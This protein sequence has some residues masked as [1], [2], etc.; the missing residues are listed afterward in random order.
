MAA[1]LRLAIRF[2]TAWVLMGAGPAAALSPSLPLRYHS[3]ADGLANLAV[4]ALA[5]DTAGQLWI[6]TENGLFVHGGARVRA[7]P[8]EPRLAVGRMVSA[9]AAGPAGEV[10]I[11]TRRGLLRWQA[12]AVTPFTRGGKL[13][14]VADGLGLAF[15]PEGRLLVVADRELLQLSLTS[16]GELEPALP[17]ALVESEGRLKEI[18]AVWVGRDGAWWLACG[19][20]LCRWH[21]GTLSVWDARQGLAEARWAGLL[22]ARDGSLWARSAQHVARL[23]PGAAAFE[24]LTTPGLGQGTVHQQQPLL[25]DRSGRILIH[26]D[27]GIARWDAGTWTLFDAGQGLD[28][29]GGVHALLFDRQGDLWLGTA[30]RGLAQWR[31]YGRWSNWSAAP[32]QAAEEVWSFLDGNDG[33]GLW[34]GTGRGTVR[35]DRR[36]AQVTE[37]AA[38]GQ[39]Q[40]QV[41][42]LARDSSRRL[43]LATFSGEL[44]RL[45][46]PRWTRIASGLPLVF[47]ILPRD[48]GLWLGTDQGLY[49]VADPQSPHPAVT[50]LGLGAAVPDD[51]I[52]VFTMCR[53]PAGDVWLAT[54]A[55]LL[56]QRPGEGIAAARPEGLPEGRV[57]NLACGR[58]GALWVHGSDGGLWQVA[59]AGGRW[60]AHRQQA[61]VLA[62]RLIM[63]LLED[64]RGWLWV[65]TDAGLVLRTPAPRW[66]R[67]DDSNGLVWSDCNQYAL[68]EDR[69]GAIWVGTSRGVSR[70]ESPEQ[71]DP[72]HAIGLRLTAARRGGD[73]FAPGQALAL[74]WSAEA[75]AIEWIAPTFANQS[76]QTVH[77]RL[78]GR[79]DTWMQTTHNEAEYPALNA[80]RYRFEAFAKNEDLGG[81]SEVQSLDIEIRPPWW[82]SLPALGAY[83]AT[84]L[85]LATL[86]HRWRTRVL[87][88]R[89][90]ELEQLVQART[91]ELSE[92]YERMRAM[93]LTDG[94]TGAMNRRAIMEA[95]Q[96]ELDRVRRGEAPV[97]LA[98]V[99]LDHFKSIND[100]HGHPAGDAVL[101][102]L[103][104]RLRGTMRPYDLVGRYGGEEFLLVL[105]GLSSD[106]AEGVHR[107]EELQRLVGQSPFELE[108]GTRLPVTCSMGAVGA[109]AGT[110][111]SVEALVAL[112]DAALYVAKRAGRDRCVIHKGATVCT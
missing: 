23:K 56:R 24:D 94:L 25:E 51:R 104:R 45:D 99:D 107:L 87:R 70:I 4:T 92:S 77:Y 65:S 72:A 78:R 81:Q 28:A 47:K 9:L 49:Q 22:Q 6:G 40:H 74:P 112:A 110:R 97:T 64:R 43:W 91:Q 48:G 82:L 103:V 60:R 8:T 18:S 2:F 106:S 111:V 32:G 90:R 34:L 41:G 69:D 61:A 1:V 30:G 54:S 73:R 68:H 62:E 59:E 31:G 42:S 44:Q 3:H 96:R 37:G 75:L 12:G 36:S 10:W 17:A 85:W 26:T 95:A 16:S 5:Q 105:P 76:A 58:Q 7:V 35:I 50:R 79:A 11:G 46:G 38:P 108:D 84:L 67:F 55:G 93:A 19:T 66:R 15:T 89:Q 20:A 33:H 57:E 86:G 80:G 63:G 109:P 52:S 14:Y 21:A 100:T 71:L 29:G 88:Q 39:V 13:P 53:S 83:A 102:G 98:L 27:T 101:A